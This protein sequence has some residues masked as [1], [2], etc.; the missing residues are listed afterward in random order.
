MASTTS[1]LLSGLTYKIVF[2]FFRLETN[3]YEK[4]LVKKFKEYKGLTPSE[5]D[6]NEF[7][8]LDRTSPL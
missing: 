3:Q 7:F 1:M 4:D 5:F 2:S 8:R 6:I